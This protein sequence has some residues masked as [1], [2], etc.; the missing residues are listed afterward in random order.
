MTSAPTYCAPVIPLRLP[1]R[2]WRGSRTHG[3]AWGFIMVMGNW[4]QQ[5]PHPGT[6]GRPSCSGAGFNLPGGGFSWLFLFFCQLGSGRGLA[7]SLGLRSSETSS[8]SPHRGWRDLEPTPPCTGMG[9]SSRL[10][11]GWTGPRKHEGAGLGVLGTG[12]PCCSWP[13]QPELGRML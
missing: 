5:R 8:S 10:W 3:R 13:P 2:R 4:C 1:G 9:S 6:A 12:A 7:V 11:P